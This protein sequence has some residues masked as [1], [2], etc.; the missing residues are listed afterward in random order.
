MSAFNVILVRTYFQ[1]SIPYDLYEAAKIDGANY[2]TIY[3]KV[4]LPLGKPIIVTKMSFL[5]D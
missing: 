1:S 3:W 5:S 4:V 2:P